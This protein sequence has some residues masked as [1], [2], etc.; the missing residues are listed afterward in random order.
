MVVREALRCS[1]FCRIISVGPQNSSGRCLAAAIRGL[2]KFMG[3]VFFRA[4]EGRSGEFA[5]GRFAGAPCATIQK[6]PI[7]VRKSSKIAG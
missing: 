2:I 4:P 5:N 6:T 1:L 7:G 3:G